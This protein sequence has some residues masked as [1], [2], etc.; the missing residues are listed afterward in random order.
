VLLALRTYA[1]GQS[2]RGSAT[3]TPHRQIIDALDAGFYASFE[4]V[5]P[6]GKRTLLALD[7]SGSMTVPISGMPLTAR[8]ASAAMA[9]VTARTEPQYEVL[10]FT[11]S[12]ARSFAAADDGHRSWGTRVVSELPISPRQ[13]LDDILKRI[14][15]LSFASTDCALPML[16]ALENKAEVDTFIIYT[17]NETWSGAVHPYQAL[18]MYREKMGIPAKLIVVGMTS[19]NFSI[20][21]P[22]DSGMLDVAGFASA[23]P[24]LIADF[25]SAEVA[26]A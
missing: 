25:S 14:N 5:E 19:T 20:A 17:D 7:V 22:N 2:A 11:G 4:A 13:R 9:M 3:W 16:W 1:S 23:V 8:E 24:T 21:D 12:G 10:G 18:R 26:R 15:N 6:T